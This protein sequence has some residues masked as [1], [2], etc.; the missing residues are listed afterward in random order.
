MESKELNKLNWNGI[1]K[2]SA[3]QCTTLCKY[4]AQLPWPIL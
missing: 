1:A 3:T 2:Y 4:V